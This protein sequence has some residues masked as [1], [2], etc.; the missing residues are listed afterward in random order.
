MN[1][2]FI[3][4][5]TFAGYIIAYNTYGRWLSAKIFELDDSLQVPSVAHADGKDFVKSKK[6][7][8]FGHH[9][10]SIAGTGPIVGPA[11]GVIWGWVPAL[12]W[13]FFGSIIMGAVHDFGTLVV[14]LRHDG[15]SIA[16]IAGD[17][18][19]PR[20]RIF[21]LIV[22]FLAVMIVISVFC[23][24][25]ASVFKLF[26][27]SV[28][29][30]WFQIPIAV[31]LGRSIKGRE[32]GVKRFTATAVLIM[33]LSVFAG[34]F[35]EFTM[36]SISGLPSTGVWTIILL[37][38]AFIAS[39]LP[40]TAL[41][42]PRDYIN[43]WQLFIAMGLM[44]S[45]AVF[46]GICGKLMMTAPA[47][48]T[49]PVGA[50]PVGPTLFIIIACGAVSGFHS[51]VS[52]G[53]SAKQLSREKDALFV[54]Y[55]SMLVEA[56]LATLV[57]V[58]VAAGIGDNSAWSAHYA[59]WSASSGLAAK[60]DAVVKGSAN[61]ML[62]IGMPYNL[63]AAVMGVFIASFAGTTLD[64]AA[65]IQRYVVAE[66]SKA[67]GFDYFTKIIP[68]AILV[69]LSSGVLAFASGA[70]GKGALMLWPMFGAVNQLLAALALI[71]VS[72]YLR[73]NGGRKFS[74]TILPCIF[75]LIITLWSV[76]VNET[77]FFRNAQWTLAVVNGSVI[78]MTVVML[79]ES[80]IVFLRRRDV[81]SA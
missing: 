78:V 42:Q 70:D 38:Y 48:N 79:I 20:M 12:L 19:S 1:A 6:G 28:F 25:I 63:S 75:M 2:L 80:V 58:A 24:V 50:P 26:P 32:T 36:P 52:S 5:I 41:L 43:A 7:V 4:I 13:I 62:S 68:A 67:C 60:L 44:L 56:A 3:I 35:M 57:L 54:G 9:F 72:L 14:S 40:V 33:Y 23:L 10:T 55:G 51:L 18:V 46:S 49:A 29:P 31:I 81:Q 8:V 74:V 45:G 61:M 53:T 15:R 34:R 39:I 71:V 59:S 47:V 69:V 11:I 77:E 37:I 64:S 16:D 73:R 27:S 76:T 66:V 30:V 17:Y 65:R 21:F 22:V